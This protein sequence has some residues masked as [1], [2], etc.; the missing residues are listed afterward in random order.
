MVNSK[1]KAIIIS[2]TKLSVGHHY[3]PECEEPTPLLL[4]ADWTPRWPSPSHPRGSNVKHGTTQCA[5]PSAIVTNALNNVIISSSLNT[6]GTVN[7]HHPSFASLE[8]TNDRHRYILTEYRRNSE[9]PSPIFYQ[10]RGNQRSSLLHPHW[11]Q[12]EQRSHIT[13]LLPA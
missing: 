4:G 9:D 5:S 1:D 10:P 12:K 8:G 6:K 11:I 7:T 13:H 2:T 3:W